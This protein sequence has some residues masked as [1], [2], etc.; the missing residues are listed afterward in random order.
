M[1]A[2]PNI[3]A[4]YLKPVKSINEYANEMDASEANA[5]EMAAKR[6]GAA[7]E[8][9]IR[10]AYQ[11]SGGDQNKLMQILQQGGSYKAAQGLQK[12]QLENQNVQSQIEERSAKTSKERGDAMKNRIEMYRDGLHDVMTPQDAAAWLQAQYQDPETKDFMNSRGAFEQ[13]ITRIPSDPAGFAQWRQQAALGMKKFVE[14]NKPTVTTRNLGGTTETISS[15]GLTGLTKVLNSIRNTQSPESAAS[16]AQSERASLRADRRAKDQAATGV[17][18]QQ[19][20]EGNF[21]AL[22]TRAVP[23]QMVRAMPVAA[24]GAGM[25]PLAGKPSETAKKELMS[26]YQ[27]KSILQGALNAIET[28]PDAF[29]FGRGVAGKMPFGETL[30]GRGEAPEQTKARAYV[31]NNVSRVINE[32]AGAAQSA[33]ELARLNAFLP[34][35][36]DNATQIKNK[37]EGFQQYL[38]DLEAGT[39]G[40]PTSPT[41]PKGGG[42]M[43]TMSAIDAE[44]A[45]R[46]GGK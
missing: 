20:A 29:S 1:A 32:R 2:D 6:Q 23:G 28:T 5:L 17:T 40:R 42:G 15:E 26:I 24:A 30:A 45:R 34:A 10:S 13:A 36:T 46:R 38:G 16:V 33:Q 43:P 44:I 14:L 21:V 9:A 3:F 25:Q 11:Q 31:F 39:K 18:Y 4:Q 35:D 37:L 7:D 19:D 22:P 12:T 8:A 27:Q 41:S